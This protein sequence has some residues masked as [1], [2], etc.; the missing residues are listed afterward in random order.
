MPSFL[1]KSIPP[2]TVTTQTGHWAPTGVGAN[3]NNQIPS[4]PKDKKNKI[5]MGM[6][7]L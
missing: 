7:V 4:I 3:S 6:W 2:P 1:A 5:I